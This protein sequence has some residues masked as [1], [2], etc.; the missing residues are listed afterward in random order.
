[1]ETKK[2]IRVVKEKAEQYGL[3]QGVITT[4]HIKNRI[5]MAQYMRLFRGVGQ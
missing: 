5:S 3:M 2:D 4:R 1:M